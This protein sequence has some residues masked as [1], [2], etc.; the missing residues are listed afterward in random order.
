MEETATVS[1]AIPIQV[2]L[3][4]AGGIVGF[5]VGGWLRVLVSKWQRWRGTSRD[6]LVEIATFNQRLEENKTVDFVQWVH[7]RIEN[8]GYR[9]CRNNT[10]TARG[11]II[12]LKIHGEQEGRRLLF[13]TTQKVPLEERSLIQKTRYE[14]PLAIIK[15]RDYNFLPYPIL[16]NACYITDSEFLTQQ[17]YKPL[18]PGSYKLDVTIEWWDGGRQEVSFNLIAPDN[19]GRITIGEINKTNQQN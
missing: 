4:I 5:F 2:V 8:V 18:H 6:P 1:T 10:Y 15:H 17:V 16:F 11:A 3:L 12:H 9:K 7:L 14:V 19:N 13:T